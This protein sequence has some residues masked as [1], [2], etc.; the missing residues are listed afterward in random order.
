MS[1]RAPVTP[2]TPTQ[3]TNP[4]A[5]E[6]MRARRSGVV[7]GATSGITA[8]PAACIAVA[9]VRRLVERQVREDDA[10]DASRQPQRART[11]RRRN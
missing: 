8:T 11:P 7:V 10:V 4:A 1:R 3:Y 9:H 2:V 6:Q 5:V